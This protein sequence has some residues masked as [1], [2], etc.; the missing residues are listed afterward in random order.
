MPESLVIYGK[1][2][3]AAVVPV[4]VWALDAFFRA[5]AKLEVAAPHTFT[6]LVDEP[7]HDDDGNVQSPRQTVH[8]RSTIVR[9]TGRE[10]AT[11]VELVLNWEPLC[12]NVWPARSYQSEVAPDDRFIIRFSSL[13][14]AET[15]GL[16]VLSINRELPALITVRSDQCEAKYVSMYPQPVAST[17]KK[18]FVAVLLFL[19]LA[20][21]VYLATLLMQFLLV[22]TPFGQA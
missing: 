21:A 15:V 13:A 1:E 16:E 7:L 10:T 4:I 20:A 14:P 22:G 18:A 3:F 9:N 11:N 2:I 19:G 5:R 6:F 8:T 12:L 17:R